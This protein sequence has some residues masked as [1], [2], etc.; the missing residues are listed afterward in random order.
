MVRP[1]V[2]RKPVARQKKRWRQMPRLFFSALCFFLLL[3]GLARAVEP[4][5]SP[6]DEARARHLF[7]ELRC[8]VC[9]NQS[10]DSSDA[11]V[12]KDLRQIV[13]EQIVSGKSDGD[14]IDYLVTRY[15]EFI[16]LK[17]RLDW[18]T[19][20]LWA[21]PLLALLAGGILLAVRFRERPGVELAAKG[22]ELSADEQ[23]ELDRILQGRETGS[24]DG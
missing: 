23:R 12:A 15:G 20:L 1:P 14:I 16:L 10:I 3:T 22:A 11:D 2:E 9:Q 13:R 5:L 17:P 21:T 6:Q 8:V 19:V 18:H 7:T 4:E 24:D